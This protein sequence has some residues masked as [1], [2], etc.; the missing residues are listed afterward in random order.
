MRHVLEI[1]ILW[2]SR[3]VLQQ[4]ADEDRVLAVVVRQLWDVITHLIV[5]GQQPAI[6]QQQHRRRRERLRARGQLKQRA[7][8]DARLLRHI[9]QP[10]ALV[11]QQLPRHPDQ[12]RHARPLRVDAHLRHQPVDR[13]H[14]RLARR[15][16]LRKA[17][18]HD[19]Q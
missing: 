3:R 17:A 8:C 10:V 2:Q 11:K 16:I 7:R 4:I 15:G 1:K 14:Q 5:D 13:R 9:R 19:R 18:A 12:D 6:M